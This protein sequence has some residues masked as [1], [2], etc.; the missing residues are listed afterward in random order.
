MVQHLYKKKRKKEERRIGKVKEER[1]KVKEERNRKKERRGK[2]RRKNGW[3]FKVSLAR[4]NTSKG[5]RG[6]V[7][8]NIRNYREKGRKKENSGR[9]KG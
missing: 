9:N 8:E 7:I 2:R 4:K 1:N 3:I 5:K 6:R